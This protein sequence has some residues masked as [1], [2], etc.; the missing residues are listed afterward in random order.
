[1]K[2]FL[3]LKYVCTWF[4][5]SKNKWIESLVEAFWLSWSTVYIMEQRQTGIVLGPGLMFG[6]IWHAY[7]F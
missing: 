5:L 7:K 3:V 6:R 2:A 4:A 1:M